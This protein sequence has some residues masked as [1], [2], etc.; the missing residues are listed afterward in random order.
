MHLN[1][2][3]ETPFTAQYERLRANPDWDV[4]VI[5]CGHNI[6]LQRPDELVRVLTR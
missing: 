3:A 2:W 4:H 6:M 1:G 5:N